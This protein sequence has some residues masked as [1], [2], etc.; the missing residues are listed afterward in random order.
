MKRSIAV[1]LVIL[2]LGI[3]VT[4]LAAEAPGKPRIPVIGMLG[5]DPA[6]HLTL[7]DAFRERLRDLGYVEGQNI[8]FESRWSRGQRGQFPALAADLVR[9][10][11]DLLVTA[12]TPATVAAQ[13]AT[14][15]IPIVMIIADSPL[16]S[17][18]VTGLARPGGNITG[19]ATVAPEIGGKRLEL[20]KEVL[21]QASR[22]AV[23]HQTPPSGQPFHLA[24]RALVAAVQGLHLMLL[25]TVADRPDQLAD[26]LAALTQARVDAL[27]VGDNPVTWVHRR[28]ILDFT[29]THHMPAIY[30]AREFVEA[31]GL[32]S[33]GINLTQNF[34]RAATYV[35]KILKGTKPGDL[36]MEQAMH[37]GLVINLKT[38]QALDLTIPPSLLF[39]AD[40]VIR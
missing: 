1:L 39:Q 6:T 36:T 18:V 15:T 10:P 7:G 31:G 35:D 29:A 8:A 3:R 33:Y 28:L 16:D 12:G 13:Q 34:W 11:V 21:P 38:A 40:E 26:A 14:A 5:D 20:L 17:G 22:V 23:L 32:V 37:F 4:P 24:A 9:L 30:S 2:T 27:Y 25:P 19:L